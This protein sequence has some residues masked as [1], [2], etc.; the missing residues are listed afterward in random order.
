[1]RQGLNLSIVRG[2]LPIRINRFKS[3]V[4]LIKLASKQ[5]YKILVLWYSLLRDRVFFQGR[6]ILGIPLSK[7]R[8]AQLVVESYTICIDQSICY[9]FIEDLILETV[10]G[11]VEDTILKQV[12]GF[13]EDLIFEKFQ[14]FVADLMLELVQ[15]IVEELTREHNMVLQRT[16][17]QQA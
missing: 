9:C 17:F 12:R 7:G 15:G 4:G 10:L 11:F 6:T 16:P 13:V 5:K 3:I 14:C 2:D 1:M 8:D